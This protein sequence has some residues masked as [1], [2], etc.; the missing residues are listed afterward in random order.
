MEANPYAAPAILETPPV[1][2]APSNAEE[3]RRLHISNEASVKSLGSLYFLGFIFL[4]LFGVIKLLTSFTGKTGPEDAG[5]AAFLLGLAALYFWI[6]RGLRRFEKGP[7]IAAIVFAC[8]G[9]LGFPI[10]TL[11]SAYI[12]NL[13]VSQKGQMVFSPQYQEIIAATPHV[14][15]KT[16]LAVW[17][18]LGICLAVIILGVILIAT[19][20]VQH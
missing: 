3:I 2:G 8:I 6:G 13:L 5:V 12:L 10:G 19:S 7:R 15:N 20:S 11:I 4:T 1:L 9:L 18:I 16:S 17:I 14:K